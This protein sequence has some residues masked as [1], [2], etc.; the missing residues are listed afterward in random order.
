LD[1]DEVSAQLD[2]AGLGRV[3][4]ELLVAGLPSIRLVSGAGRSHLGGAAELPRETAWPQ[5]NDRPLSLVAQL[6]L[7]EFAEF[8]PDALLPPRGSLAFFYD[9]E[10]Q[11]WGFDP[12][13][14]DGAAVVFV[15]EGSATDEQSAGE[16]FTPLHLDARPE[17]TLPPEPDEFGLDERENDAY[18]DML[19]VLN[20]T[21]HRCLGHPDQIQADMRLEAQLVTNGLYVGDPAGYEDPR[22][23]ELAK[24]VHAWRLL[25][26]VDSDEDR[27]M[28]WGDVGRIYYWIREAD[29]RRGAFD[30]TWLILQCT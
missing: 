27:E 8:D 25:L 22:A 5:R 18:F 15:P 1:K 4:T 29:L 19:G 9:A 17:F 23:E 16:S 13:D 24:G 6:F 20:D 26:Q 14:G 30:A 10:D 3:K 12:A 28:Y 2:R 7:D 11:P 21:R